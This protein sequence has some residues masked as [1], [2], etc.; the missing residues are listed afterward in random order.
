MFIKFIQLILTSKTKCNDNVH[1]S[2]SLHAV[3]QTFKSSTQLK[4]SDVPFLKFWNLP[5]FGSN[6]KIEFRKKTGVWG[7]HELFVKLVH[8]FENSSMDFEIS[9]QKVEIFRLRTRIRARKIPY[10]FYYTCGGEEI[11]EDSFQGMC[12]DLHERLFFE[13]EDFGACIFV[14]NCKNTIS[15][16]IK[17]INC[18]IKVDKEDTEQMELFYNNSTLKI[19]DLEEV[20]DKFLYE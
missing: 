10:V 9:P 12:I 3:T 8:N 20:D 18:L 19:K 17:N 6:Q 11:T 2:L 5:D 1:F 4:M 7:G 15:H 13:N 14:R 16:N